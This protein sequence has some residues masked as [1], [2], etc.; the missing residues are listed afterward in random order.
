MFCI[1]FFNLKSLPYVLRYGKDKKQKIEREIKMIVEKGSQ[2]QWIITALLHGY[3]VSRQ[4]FGYSKKEAVK[5][6]KLMVK[7]NETFRVI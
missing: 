4:F 3:V 5:R 2:G 6:F 7:D 1:K